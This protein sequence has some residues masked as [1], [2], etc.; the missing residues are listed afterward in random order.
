MRKLIL[1]VILIFSIWQSNL[2]AQ[3]IPIID[4]TNPNWTIVGLNERRISGI[5][6]REAIGELTFTDFSVEAITFRWT[7]KTSTQF[8]TLGKTFVPGFYIAAEPEHNMIFQAFLTSKDWTFIITLA[9]IQFIF[10][11]TKNFLNLD[12]GK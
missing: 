5:E 3:G 11:L 2:A 9:D 7:S 4:Y 10:H 8:I 1:T 12:Y 6:L